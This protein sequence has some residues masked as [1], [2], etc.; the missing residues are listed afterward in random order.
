MS[1]YTKKLCTFLAFSFLSFTANS[2]SFRVQKTHFISLEDSLSR[3]QVSMEL[4]DALAIKLSDSN[5]FLKGIELYIQLDPEN[6]SIS[7]KVRWTLFSSVKPFPSEERFDY[8]GTTSL[9]GSFKNSLGVTVRIPFDTEDSLKKDALSAM[10]EKLQSV[11]DGYIFLRLSALDDTSR[12]LLKGKA[13]VF[14]KQIFKDSGK[15]H[16]KV[17]FPQ[18]SQEHPYSVFIDGLAC[19]SVKNIYTLEAGMHNVS[20][21]SDYYRNEMRTISIEPAK[22]SELTVEF[23][24]IKPLL[25]I[26]VPE[27]GLLFLDEEKIEDFNHD[28]I[29]TSGEHT[30]KFQLGGYEI[31]KTLNAVNGRSYTFL[32]NMEALITEEE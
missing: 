11:E 15:L 1:F 13:E 6:A 3:K 14:V 18:D 32:I 5:V 25:H 20:I 28:I 16:L 9:S 19:P 7:E 29:M 8:S 27:G 24:D 2:E 12:E 23:Q 4:N 21:V 31:I 26:A 10:S 17:I 30:L 22:T